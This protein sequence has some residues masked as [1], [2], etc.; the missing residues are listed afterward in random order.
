MTL[1]LGFL[2]GGLV[3]YCFRVS[4]VVFGGGTGAA[5]V[6]WRLRYVTPAAAAAIVASSLLVEQG[7]AKVAPP[8]ELLA[9]AAGLIAV[10]RGGK[11]WLTLAVGLPVYWLALA[12][13]V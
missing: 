5:D 12:I 3:T 6:A 2:I 13:G 9:V 7:A 4:M 8:A 11:G 10:R 1:L